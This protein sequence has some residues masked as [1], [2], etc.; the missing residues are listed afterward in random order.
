M[1]YLHKQIKYLKKRFKQ[2]KTYGYFLEITIIT[3]AAHV[4]AGAVI[5]ISTTCPHA[6]V[7]AV[8]KIL[9]DLNQQ[10]LEKIQKYMHKKSIYSHL[11]IIH[12]IH[13]LLKNK[14]WLQ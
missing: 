13:I 9:L 10:F 6:R 8:G 14:S 2:D 7:M 11:R 1:L 4:G 12:E 5:A 3:N